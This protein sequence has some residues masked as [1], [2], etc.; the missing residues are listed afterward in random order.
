LED[1]WRYKTFLDQ[2]TQKDFLEGVENKR[3]EKRAR[4]NKK[5]EASGADGRNSP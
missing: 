3:M 1:L 4:K 2:I 5:L